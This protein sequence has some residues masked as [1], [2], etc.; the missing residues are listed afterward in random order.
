L[1]F[2]KLLVFPYKSSLRVIINIQYLLVITLQ[3]INFA[4]WPR[5]CSIGGAVFGKTIIESLH[6]IEFMASILY[7]PAVN[8]LEHYFRALLEIALPHKKYE[9]CRSFEELSQKLRNPHSN[10]KVTVL[11]AADREE[12]ARILS[13]GSLL[14]DVKIILI[15]AVEDK[16]TM[17]KVHTL[18]PRYVTWMDG[19]LSNVVTVF[20][21]MVGLYDSM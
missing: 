8:G 11:F 2:N 4:I 3:Y 9:I 15:L 1:F 14:A 18:R 21:R 20:K 13:L 7:I 12:I 10:V 5:Y 17:L 19:D 16:E 6:R